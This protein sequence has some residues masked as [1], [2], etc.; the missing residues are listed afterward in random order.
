MPC[1][2][3]PPERDI[4]ER[5]GSFDACRSPAAAFSVRPGSTRGVHNDGQLP[6]Y[7]MGGS[8]FAVLK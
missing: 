8:K 7:T 5:Y 4:A 3:R 2:L 6:F 1:T